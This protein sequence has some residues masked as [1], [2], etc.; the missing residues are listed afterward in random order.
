MRSR[1]ARRNSA[2]SSLERVN[3]N[4]WVE[5][6]RLFSRLYQP[7]PHFHPLVLYMFV[8]NFVIYIFVIEISFFRTPV[9]DGVQALSAQGSAISTMPLLDHSFTSSQWTRMFWKELFPWDGGLESHQ[10]LSRRLFSI[11]MYAIQFKPKFEVSKLQ[12]FC[13]QFDSSQI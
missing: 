13:K 3:R 4:F 12:E 5:D 10:R 11:L 8:L 1:K 9:L 7:R 2:S 6:G